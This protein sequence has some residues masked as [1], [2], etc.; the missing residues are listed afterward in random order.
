MAKKKKEN[1]DK[2]EVHEDLKGF[3]ISINEFGEIV[4]SMEIDKL[5]EFLNENVDDKKLKDHPPGESDTDEDIHEEEKEKESDD[6][7]WSGVEE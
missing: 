2:P 7:L 1:K 6:D 4:T 5:N 3:E